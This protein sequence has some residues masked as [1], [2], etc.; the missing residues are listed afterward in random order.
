M[1]VI[2]CK[3]CGNEISKKAVICPKCGVKVNNKIIKII[4]IFLL[5]IVGGGLVLFFTFNFINNM[6]LRTINNK[7]FGKWNLVSDSSKIDIYGKNYNIEKSFNINEVNIFNVCDTTEYENGYYINND[8]I[9]L[10][11]SSKLLIDNTKIKDHICF[12]LDNN[13][14]KQVECSMQVHCE[15]SIEEQGNSSIPNIDLIYSKY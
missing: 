15:Y 11:L 12:K 13:E 8:D 9:Y 14:L 6:K 10:F 3:E 2:K 4:F 7:I 1:E 5:L